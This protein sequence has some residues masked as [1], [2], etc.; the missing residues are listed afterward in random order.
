VDLSEIGFDNRRVIDVVKQRR[1]SLDGPLERR[2]VDSCWGEVT[3]PLS[4]LHRLPLTMLGQRRIA[5]AIDERK[6]MSVSVS[7]RLAV[8]NE[9]DLGRS[10]RCLE[11]PLSVFN[12]VVTHRREGSSERA[13]AGSFA[14]RTRSALAWY[15]YVTPHRS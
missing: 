1:S 13:S 7:G 2:H 4:D 6:G 10:R 5:L 15:P 9:K 12:L 14:L 11:R 8:A 3:K